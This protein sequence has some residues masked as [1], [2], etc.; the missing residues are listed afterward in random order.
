[1]LL[2]HQPADFKVS[3]VTDW[4]R[5]VV[6]GHPGIPAISAKAA[7]F[8]LKQSPQV[9][10]LPLTA[11]QQKE[12]S[13]VNVEL[14]HPDTYEAGVVRHRSF[15]SYVLWRFAKLIGWDRLRARQVRQSGFD[16]ERSIKEQ[17]LEGSD[18][19]RQKLFEK[20]LLDFGPHYEQKHF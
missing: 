5:F 6:A 18:P 2:I 4:L 20:I 11:S 14:I 16:P 3:R 7:L 13:F 15:W 19:A 1:N 10:V 17:L 9:P 12:L 8:T